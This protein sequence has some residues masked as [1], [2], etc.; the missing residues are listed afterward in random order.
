MKDSATTYVSWPMPHL[1]LL[2][3]NFM[4]VHGLH[5]NE[6]QRYYICLLANAT[7]LVVTGQLHER[8]RL[9]SE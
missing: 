5:L 8:S 9:E 4:N 6:G 3:D 7:S 2:Q 1:L